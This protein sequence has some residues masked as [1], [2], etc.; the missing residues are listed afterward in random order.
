MKGNA[1]GARIHVCFLTSHVGRLFFFS[2]WSD[3]HDIH[4]SLSDMI[5]LPLF[6]QEH[7]DIIAPC[8]ELAHSLRLER[9]M[10]D[11]RQIIELLA[12]HLG[13]LTILMLQHILYERMG[14]V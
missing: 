11:H 12:D 1:K 7:H 5:I 10:L 13:V 14:A 8:N 9:C 2:F 4:A 3:Q 6:R